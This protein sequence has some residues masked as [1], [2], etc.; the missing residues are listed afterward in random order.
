MNAALS[1][2]LRAAGGRRLMW[3]VAV[4]AIAA[5]LAL[6]WEWLTA[7]GVAS[8]LVSVLPCLAMCALGLCMNRRAGSTG[9]TCG[10]RTGQAQP[11]RPEEEKR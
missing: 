11:G 4:L 3:G 1:T 8:L 9:S 2:K 10:Q 7:V 6:G 5:A